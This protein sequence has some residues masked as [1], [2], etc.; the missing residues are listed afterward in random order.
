MP[1]DARDA[2]TSSE[3]KLIYLG[4]TG[5]PRLLGLQ[6]RCRAVRAMPLDQAKKAHTR[7]GFKVALRLEPYDL[8]A[9]LGCIATGK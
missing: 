4:R 3:V 7:S 1:R 5:M 8:N 9:V 6:P 2:A